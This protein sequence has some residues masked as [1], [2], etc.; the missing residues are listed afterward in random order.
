MA[1]HGYDPREAPRVWKVMAKVQGPHRTNFFW[2]NH[3]NESTRRSY[4]MNELKNNY[5]DLDYS[6]VQKNAESFRRVQV[7]A[8]TAAPQ[9]KT[10][11]VRT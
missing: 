5:S 3:D 9:K 1:E 6:K 7:L 10:I 11:R 8:R 4:L 2:S